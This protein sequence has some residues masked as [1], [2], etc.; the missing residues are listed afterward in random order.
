MR[1]R[2]KDFERRDVQLVIVTTDTQLPVRGSL[3][4]LSDPGTVVSATYG[5]PFQF[6]GGN[7]PASF[8][9]DRK[10]VIRLRYMEPTYRTRPNLDT[11]V[12]DIAALGL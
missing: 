2:L 4:I 8:L 11:V 1:D 3:P 10:G 7:R 6:G 5:V 12:S 9:M